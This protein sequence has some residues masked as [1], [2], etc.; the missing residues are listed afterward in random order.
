[1]AEHRFTIPTKQK[2]DN[3]WPCISLLKS[4]INISGAIE[5]RFYTELV[6]R[7]ELDDI[8]DR[9]DSSNWGVLR[10]LFTEKFL[11]KSQSEWEK[12]FDGTDSCVTP[13]IPLTPQGN[14]SIAQ[15][16]ESP[17][18]D[19]SNINLAMLKPGTGTKDVM[20]EWVGWTVGR[21]YT[22][23]MEGTVNIAS[24]ARL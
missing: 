14:R 18:L 12:V 24:S 16:S 1:M 23:D 20:R 9:E 7:L 5:P 13:V 21:E 11:Q 4:F 19:V 8:P 10:D 15:L 6:K 17:G 22:V 2:M 3:I